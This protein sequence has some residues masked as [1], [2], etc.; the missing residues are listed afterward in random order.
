MPVKQEVFTVDLQLGGNLRSEIS[1][2]FNLSNSDV[3]VAGCLKYCLNYWFHVL[4]VRDFVLDIIRSGYMLPF[5]HMPDSCHLKNNKSAIEHT[6]FVEEA[7]TKL[8]KDK[9]RGGVFLACEQALGG[10]E[11]ERKEE[12]LYVHLKFCCSA[13]LLTF[14]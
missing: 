11:G 3:S 8:L 4:K 13:P 10:M 1:D 6:L 14:L 2:D 5:H 9:Y 7:I 12:G